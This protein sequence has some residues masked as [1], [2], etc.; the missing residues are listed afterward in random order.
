MSFVSKLIACISKSRRAHIRENE[1][2]RV[3]NSSLLLNF[4]RD[5]CFCQVVTNVSS[6]DNDD[7]WADIAIIHPRFIKT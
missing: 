3:S 6:F 1:F 5:Q 7:N 4:S 2:L